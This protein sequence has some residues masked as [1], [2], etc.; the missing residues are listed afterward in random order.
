MS[1]VACIHGP[2]STVPS[3]QHIHTTDSPPDL[4]HLA[5]SLQHGSVVRGA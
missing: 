3:C 2:R 5:S 1:S 4:A